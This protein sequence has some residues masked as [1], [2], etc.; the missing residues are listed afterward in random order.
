[1]TSPP[2]RDSL[3]TRC[4]ASAGTSYG[5]VSATSRCSIETAE[6]IDLVLGLG[7]SCPTCVVRKFWYHQKDGHFRPELCT[8]L[9]R[10]DRRN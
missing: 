1:M 7:A 3:P 9:W 2:A 6:R 10:I 8:K 5:P 4:S